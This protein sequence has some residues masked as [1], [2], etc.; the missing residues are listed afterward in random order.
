MTTK[1]DVHA[2]IDKLEALYIEAI[3]K[4]DISVEE[5]FDRVQTVKQDLVKVR[6]IVDKVGEN[7]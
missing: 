6:Q 4:Q 2:E 1:L 3:G 5:Y 7:K